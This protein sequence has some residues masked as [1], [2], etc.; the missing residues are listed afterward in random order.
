MNTLSTIF[1]DTFGD[2][3]N[4]KCEVPYA[5]I[6]LLSICIFNS[7]RRLEKLGNG[8]KWAF[9]AW[10]ARGRGFESRRPDF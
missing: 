7:L 1:A 3:L 9:S 8:Q 10:G 2:T 4:R 6:G 5:N